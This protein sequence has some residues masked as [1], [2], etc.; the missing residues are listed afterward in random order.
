M[1]RSVRE[2]KPEGDKKKLFIVGG[3][4][5]AVVVIA[6]IIVVLLTMGGKKP[7][8]APGPAQPGQPTNAVA[9]PEPPKVIEPPKPLP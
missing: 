5:A 4:V 9:T 3:A 1:F 8:P 2:Q 7:A 6:I